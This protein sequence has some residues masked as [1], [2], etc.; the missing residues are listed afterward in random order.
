MGHEGSTCPVATMATGISRS[1]AY[2]GCRAGAWTELDR[3]IV[4]AFDAMGGFVEGGRLSGRP[5]AMAEAIVTYCTGH[6]AITGV[7]PDGD[8]DVWRDEVEATILDAKLHVADA[9]F[10]R[11]DSDDE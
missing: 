7:P 6:I 1:R 2:W 5:D 3:R 4:E 10:G 9:G 11:D 8:G